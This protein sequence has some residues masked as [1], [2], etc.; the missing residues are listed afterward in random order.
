[1]TQRSRV[2]A[3]ACYGVA[4]CDGVLGVVEGEADRLL[5]AREHVL[6]SDEPG[7]CGEGK[8][9][10]Y[11]MGWNVKEKTK[12]GIIEELRRG[13]LVLAGSRDAR[14]RKRR[15]SCGACASAP[16]APQL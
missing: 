6:R 2:G 8:G 16:H 4:G 15:W 3:R 7:A 12:G 1:M 9:G 14:V 11:V 10:D 5:D 13:L